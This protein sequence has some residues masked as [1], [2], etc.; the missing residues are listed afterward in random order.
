VIQNIE[1]EPD[2]VNER[3]AE[4]GGN[5]RPFTF[6]S[7]PDIIENFDIDN[8]RNIQQF[9]THQIIVFRVNPEYVALYQT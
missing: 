3:F 7:E 4:E 2:Y 1:E 9:G 5:R 6:I 8:R